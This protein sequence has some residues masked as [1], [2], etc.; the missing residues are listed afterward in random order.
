MNLP[1]KR[2]R[3]QPLS[4]SVGMSGARGRLCLSCSLGVATRYLNATR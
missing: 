1:T 3:Q 2:S 4:A